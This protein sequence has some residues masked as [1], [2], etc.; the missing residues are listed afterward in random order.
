MSKR[1]SYQA[2]QAF[3]LAPFVK[4]GS[5]TCEV[6]VNGSLVGVATSYGYAM[7]TLDPFQGTRDIRGTMVNV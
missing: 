5:S 2:L 3:L 1:I 4:E 7:Q 6:R